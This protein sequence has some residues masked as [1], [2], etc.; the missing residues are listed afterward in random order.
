MDE[1]CRALE[2][3][4]TARPDRDRISLSEVAAHLDEGDVRA[5]ALYG[6]RL[7]RLRVKGDPP[8]SVAMEPTNGDTAA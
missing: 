6:V 2:E 7:L 4:A 3:L 5:V 1:L 8:H